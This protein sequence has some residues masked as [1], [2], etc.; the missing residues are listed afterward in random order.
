MQPLA[1]LWTMEYVVLKM[2]FK[3]HVFRVPY[4]RIFFYFK[5]NNIV[6]EM[7]AWLASK[8]CFVFACA[9]CCERWN[10]P[11]IFILILAFPSQI[12]IHSA[13]FIH[14]SWSSYV[15]LNLNTLK[16]L[17]ALALTYTLP[18]PYLQLH[19]ELWEETL[20]LASTS[21]HD[22]FLWILVVLQ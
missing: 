6:G 12:Q 11:L 5:K 14:W 20:Q 9:L 1:I 16:L 17:L 10:P 18:C 3:L 15:G 2:A 8:Y 13:S 21:Y 4:I 22:C 7:W 19:H